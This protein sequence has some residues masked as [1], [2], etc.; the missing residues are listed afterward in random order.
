MTR[1]I[2]RLPPGEIPEGRADADS[3]PSCPCAA[4]QAEA[5]AGTGRY[6]ARP[7]QQSN[8]LKASQRFRGDFGI[9]Q[10][11]EGGGPTVARPVAWRPLRRDGNGQRVLN[12]GKMLFY[13]RREQLQGNKGDSRL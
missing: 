6:G 12:F 13:P 8:F 7:S 5:R 9:V 3:Q 1:N 11:C 2:H 4:A 10:S